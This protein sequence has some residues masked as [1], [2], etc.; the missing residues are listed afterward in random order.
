MVA[1]VIEHEHDH[2]VKGWRRWVFQ[3]IIKTLVQC[4]LYSL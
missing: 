1:T 4:T 3:P 2:G